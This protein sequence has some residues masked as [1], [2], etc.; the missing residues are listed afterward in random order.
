MEFSDFGAFQKILK[1]LS[2]NLC[3]ISHVTFLGIYYHHAYNNSKITFLTS[4]RC[5]ISLNDEQWLSEV[6]DSEQ[7]LFG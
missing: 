6:S 3:D 1:M 2:H 4:L 5:Q 7:W